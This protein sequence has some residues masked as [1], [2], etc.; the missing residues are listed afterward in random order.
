M[1]SH[2][3]AR[4]VAALVAAMLLAAPVAGSAAVLALGPA[5]ERAVLEGHLFFLEDP[6]GALGIEE[7]ARPERSAGFRPYPGAHP[8]FSFSASAYWLRF[9]LARD[10]GDA[11][12]WLLSVGYPP[13]DRIELFSPRP[14][15]QGF[16]RQAAGDHLPFHAREVHEPVYDFALPAGPGEQTFYLRVQ[17]ESALTIP[18]RLRT[19]QALDQDR[20]GESLALGLFFGTLLAL[21]LYNLLL[22]LTIR[23][24]SYL[25]YVLF[26]TVTG[27]ALF[28]YNGLAYQFLWPEAVYW[29]NRSTI[30]LPLA[31]LCAATLFTRS[32]LMVPQL[33]PKLDAA[34]IALAVALGLFA[35]LALGAISYAASAYVFSALGIGV[36]LT[37]I[38]SGVLSMLRGYRPARYFLIA[39]AVLLMGLIAHALRAFGVLPGNTFT[40]YG[41]QIG[42]GLEMILLSLALAS[43]ITELKRDKEHA[44]AQALEASRRT[45]RELESLVGQ[46]VQELAEL[47]STLQKEV[48]ERRKAQ[49][50][51]LRMAHHDPL[52]GLPNR[53]LFRDRFE[54]AVS[55]ARRNREQF[56]LM[57]IDLDGFKEI[58]DSLGHDAGDQVLTGVA[59]TL[60]DCTRQTDTIARFGG[61]EFVLLLGEIEIPED[62]VRIAGKIIATLSRPMDLGGEIRQITASVGISIYPDDGH[63]LAPLLNCADQAM[64][65]AKDG[66]GSRYAFHSAQPELQSSLSP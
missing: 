8:S 51:L 50:A 27:L 14:G 58:N 23:D 36:A 7:V 12:P 38:G 26:V 66:G 48:G 46:R 3:L 10:P 43:R 57:L 9:T 20:A 4:H 39:W 49:A 63:E 24:V 17:S 13:L 2:W 6:S 19:A 41:I 11:R 42:A 34:L 59:K 25:Y 52:T 21:A 30:V 37:L 16:D 33:A 32:F 45:E 35:L 28:S 54:M 44:Q 1:L 29:N 60:R 5:L 15:G 31:A 61:D 22:T 55:T 62:A 47:N 64:Y 65:R 56:A 18:L 53:L 40:V